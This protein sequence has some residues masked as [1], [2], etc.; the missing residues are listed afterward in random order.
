MYDLKPL[1][2]YNLLPRPKSDDPNYKTWRKLSL[3]IG[4]WITLQL[5]RSV[6]DRLE[7][8][9]GVTDYADDTYKVILQMMNA[10]EEDHSTQFFLA[11]TNLSVD[12]FPTMEDFVLKFQEL[13]KR[14]N[15]DKT[16]ITPYTATLML[17]KKV[18]TELPTWVESV[19]QNQGSILNEKMTE[20]QFIVL[21]KQ[22][23]VQGSRKDKSFAAQKS[24]TL[25]T[26]STAS[27][28]NRKE[29]GRSRKSRNRGIETDEK[30]SYPRINRPPPGTNIAEYVREWLNST[31]QRVNGRCT[32]CYADGHD[33]AVCWRLRPDLRSEEW[34]PYNTKAWIYEGK[35]ILPDKDKKPTTTTPNMQV[36]NM[37]TEADTF[38]FSFSGM[39]IPNKD[40]T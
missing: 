39:A 13:I 18:R 14:A 12:D 7:Q 16:P 35:P 31:E 32:F 36:A 33:C 20:E 29:R 21:C 26:E 25:I 37:A 40:P 19:K 28:P 23:I 8:Q 9:P 27:T 6:F 24:S 11:A 34:K 5:E 1:I 10:Q 3:R 17:F 38:D 4:T 2:D 15:L 22:V 30:Q